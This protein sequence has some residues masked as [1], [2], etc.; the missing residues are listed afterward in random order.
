MSMPMIHLMLGR[1]FE[2]ALCDLMGYVLNYGNTG[3]SD[4]ITGILCTHEENGS[5]VFSMAQKTV[6]NDDSARF[7][8]EPDAPYRIELVQES[9]I[10]IQDQLVHL[11]SY[12]SR[13][14][15]RK[16]TINSN[17]QGAVLNVCIYLPMYDNNAWAAAK[18]L[19][20]A[21]SGQNRN[22]N[23]DLFMFASDLAYLFVPED[24]Q[25]E[26]AAE[27]MRNQKSC[28]DILRDVIDFKEHLEDSKRFGH[29]IVMQNCN[30]NGLSLALD[31]DSFVRVIGEYALATMTSYND[32]FQPNAEI[33]GRPIHSFG[34]CMLNLDKYYYIRYLLSKAYVTILEREGV[35]VDSLDVNEPSQIVQKALSGDNERYKFYRRF[36]EH[37]INGYLA[38]GKSEEEIN[39][40]AL[41][42]ID[43][44]IENL[45]NSVTAF[46]KDDSLS[47]PAKRVALA[48]LLGMDDELMVGDMFNPEQLLFRDTYLDCIEMF[49]RANNQLL[50]KSPHNLYVDIPNSLDSSQKEYPAHLSNQAVLCDEEIDFKQM[51]K[52]L[53][54]YDLKIRRQTEYIRALEKELCDCHVQHRQSEE[55]DK[56]LTKDGFYYRG[57]VYKF[58][59]IETIPL[60][61]TYTPRNCV[62]PRSVDLRKQFAPVKNQGDVGSCTTF[63][64]LSI[65]EYI[66]GKGK[67]LDTDLSERYLYYNTRCEVLRRTGRSDAPIEAAGEGTSFF[68][69]IKSLQID[70]ACIEKLCPYSEREAFDV[71]PSDEAYLDGKTR[72]VTEAM[73]VELKEHAIKSALYEGFPVAISVKLFTAFAN[74]DHGFITIPKEEEIRQAAEDGISSNHAMVI[75]GYSDEYKVFVVRNSWGTE[76]GENGYCFI[77]YSYITDVRLT[78]Q[79][80]IISGTNLVSADTIKDKGISYEIAPFDRFN[81]EINAAII[82]TLIGEARFEKAELIKYRTELYASYSQ[83]EKRLMNSEVRVA[84][85]NGTKERLE[86]EILEIRNQEHENQT[87]EDSRI[88][89][90]DKSNRKVNLVFVAIILLMIV[91]AFTLSKIIPS[92]EIVKYFLG[93][94]T[95]GIVGM[96]IWWVAY[97]Q[98]RKNIR[99]E[100]AN[101]SSILEEEKQSRQNGGADNYGYLGLYTKALELRMFMPWLVMRKLSEK[102]RLLEQKYQVMVSYTLNLREWYNS[103]KSKF[104]TMNPESNEPFISLLS[105]KSLDAYYEI[106]SEKITKGIRLSAL[107]DE[108]YSIENEAIVKFQNNLKNRIISILNDSLK[109][110]TVYKYLTGKCTFEFAKTRKSNVHNLL[111]RIAEKSEVF[112]RLGTSPITDDSINSTTNVLF[113]YDIGKDIDTW[114]RE[115]QQDFSD[116]VT[117]VSIMSPF[118]L[119]YLQM[120]RLPLDECLDLYDS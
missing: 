50:R 63:A 36:Y 75:C 64:L 25:A 105:N 53:K 32:V 83:I 52:N 18:L 117:H 16:I 3:L 119:T 19:I 104:G 70:G 11:K 31:W 86:W 111:R 81:P 96:L 47:L 21:I 120:K 14:F 45:V 17:T 40:Q 65:F 97:L 76:Y 59:T 79:A 46:L 4:F 41:K 114:N 100:H 15:D 87:C 72:L 7:N 34:L 116:K 103:E 84:L 69:A 51:C 28:R 56:V 95:F 5:L 88:E 54:M 107:F 24:K 6:V 60:E 30:A 89:A 112:I 115:F 61:K 113:S 48:Q 27:L 91:G 35:N 80:C 58:D 55:K 62:Y 102:N 29:I 38:E 106:N 68:D 82:R 22:I 94:L 1:T 10:E 9:I 8:S 74:P 44:D 42:D 33:E 23:V 73:N 20:K 49:V 77:P 66:L 99:K 93:A 78:N 26:L 67:S 92:R 110:F 109:D 13:L 12:F 118:K 2:G 101:V 37:R 57:K 90:L 39:A 98:N 108:G 43:E 85:V 71:R